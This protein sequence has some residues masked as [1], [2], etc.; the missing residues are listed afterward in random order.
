M[1][2]LLLV[3]SESQHITFMK[4]QVLSELPE[5]LKNWLD[6]DVKHLLWVLDAPG[7]VGLFDLK[8]Q[9]W[10][11]HN[12]G[13]D[14]WFTHFSKEISMQLSAQSPAIL[15]TDHE[16]QLDLGFSLISYLQPVKAR[17]IALDSTTLVVIFEQA[18]VS[19]MEFGY[20]VEG[21]EL[22]WLKV[23]E[24]QEFTSELICIASEDG[25]FQLLNKSWT[26][27]LGWSLEELTSRPWFDFVHPDDLP[28]TSEA[29][30]RLLQEHRLTSF[31]NRYRC[32]D[33]GYKWL[34][35]TAYFFPE[36]LQVYAVAR[37][38][39]LQKETEQRLNRS[40]RIVQF[41]TDLL[42]IAGFD[43]FLKV[44]NPAW[45]QVLG[46]TEQELLN[47]PW[48]QLVHPEDLERAQSMMEANQMG[49]QLTTYENRFRCKDGS[50]RWLSWNS[51]PFAD[52]GVMYSVARDITDAKRAAQ[53]AEMANEILRKLT[54]QVP[55]VVYQYLLRPDGTSCFPF[56]SEGIYDIYGVRPEEVREN[57]S[58]VFSRVHP[59]DLD[60]VSKEI[61][62][63][64]AHLTLFHSRFR[65]KFPDG[66]VSWRKSD[67]RP[68]RL[69]DGST[70]WYGIITDI[71][72]EVALHSMV[73]M[74]ERK[75]SHMHELMK[76][77]I[78]NASSA[79][80]VF[81]TQMRYLFVSERFKQEYGLTGRHVEGLRHYD[82]FPNLPT[83]I[84]EAHR[85]ANLGMLVEKKEDAFEHPDG[86]ISYNE[87]SCRP[88]YNEDGEIGGHILYLDIITERKKAELAMERSNRY[89]T[90]LL[91]HAN[92]PII[93]WDAKYKITRFNH[94]F[95]RFSGYQASEVLGKPLSILFLPHSLNDSLSKVKATSEG[96]SW[97]SVEIQIRCKTG[98]SRI[99]LWNSTN[100]YTDDGKTLLET[101]AQGQDITERIKAENELQLAF[102][103]LKLLQNA[104]NK[105]PVHVYMKDLDLKYFYGN[106]LALELLGEDA[107]S[108]L[109]KPDEAYFS[110]DICL[111][112]R[113]IDSRVLSGEQ[114]VEP[115][116]VPDKNGLIRHYLEVKTPITDP[117]QANKIVGLL[118]V[119]TD[120]TDT[121]ENMK[122][123]EGLLRIEEAQN[124]RLRNFTHI[125]SHNLRSH[126]AN[127]LGIM[128]LIDLED[129]ELA[130]STYIETLKAS[131][132]HLSDTIKNLN[133]VLDINLS[134]STEMQ[135]VD[136]CHSLEQT[137]PS[138]GQLAMNAGVKIINELKPGLMVIGFPA[139]IDSLVL[140]MLTNAIKFRDP[141]KSSQIV[142]SAAKQNE[143]LCVRYADNGLGIDLEKH[144]AKLFGMYKTFHGHPDS[145]GLG[146]FITKNQVE[147][148]GGKIEVSSKVGEGTTF[149]VFLRL[150]AAE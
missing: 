116:Q 149:T 62:E 87:W 139:Y 64:A 23:A 4:T 82:L 71:S 126:I 133:E 2:Y 105:V 7:G 17:G 121:I 141:A 144:G 99:A 150:A 130:H 32:S 10:E 98:E 59:D 84:L 46:W 85:V 112:L 26:K 146:L 138:I 83:H 27:L 115:L 86:S 73:Q 140:N 69:P 38:I 8:V 137:I 53:E 143:L 120:I 147:A 110:K 132:N 5:K 55:G 63:S 44:V 25:Y 78:E 92:A 125:V 33:G 95:E 124:E 40:D 94:A 129:P 41:A 1:F 28:K 3:S 67:A 31:E 57:G 89:L 35:W 142:I 108:L 29:S 123:I 18:P 76:Y 15:S 51:H 34:G 148:M 12:R 102:N 131:A 56:A 90:G 136:L 118:G 6:A 21:S 65:V 66:T 37:D 14:W 107:S 42:C 30:S 135:P 106:E 52:E 100:I 43:G 145:K 91:N 68:E 47:K 54:N 70:L 122:R 58:I 77:V 134:Q 97:D 36:S 74:S 75:L 109:G 9:A 93:T 72:N 45:T 113:E 49:K 11:W 60:R 117:L 88:W 24:F 19:M 81:D 79:V 16:E 103:R 22:D 50:Y 13:A 61:F 114:T 80:V 20:S 119:S 96:N 104:L 128:T 111:R 101:M 48:Q 127:M 39:S